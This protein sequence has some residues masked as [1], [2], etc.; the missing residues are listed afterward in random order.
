MYTAQGFFVCGNGTQQEK[1][2]EGFF[3]SPCQDVAAS[4][5]KSC[6]F[7]LS[8]TKFDCKACPDSRGG[9]ARDLSLAVTYSDRSACPKEKIMLCGGK[10]VCDK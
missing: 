4:K 2:V 7:N 10:L 3:A 8:K 5:C 6:D 1:A 9:R